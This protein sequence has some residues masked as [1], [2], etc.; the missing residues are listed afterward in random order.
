MSR[1]AWQELTDDVGDITIHLRLARNHPG[2]D[3]GRASTRILLEHYRQ[4]AEIEMQAH[5]DHLAGRLR[6]DEFLGL[7][8]DP[9]L[10]DFA[11]WLKRKVFL[12]D[13]PVGE[14]KRLI[15]DYPREVIKPKRKTKQIKKLEKLVF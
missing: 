7:R 5:H 14:V 10:E 15:G 8:V 2:T 11:N 4:A 1:R 13:D 12:S 6:E 9:V 3:C